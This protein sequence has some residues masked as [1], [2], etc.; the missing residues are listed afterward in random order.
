MEQIRIAPGHTKKL[1]Q[2]TVGKNRINEFYQTNILSAHYVHT[3]YNLCFECQ[4]AD[5]KAASQELGMEIAD[6]AVLNNYLII[7]T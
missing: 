4:V 1:H 5:I 7:N 6:S 2:N 3:K